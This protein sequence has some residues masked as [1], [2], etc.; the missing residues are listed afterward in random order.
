[1][2]D[3]AAG[4][5]PKTLL[6]PAPRLTRRP[7]TF[8]SRAPCSFAVYTREKN[9]AVYAETP[10]CA[11]VFGA[12]KTTRQAIQRRGPSARLYETPLTRPR[13]VKARVVNDPVS[14]MGCIAEPGGGCCGL[15]GLAL[16]L[17]RLRARLIRRLPLWV[18][19]RVLCE[20]ASSVALAWVASRFRMQPGDCLVV[21]Q[22]TSSPPPAPSAPL[23]PPLSPLHR[24][25]ARKGRMARE[26][27]HPR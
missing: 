26:R 6:R 20:S 21:R 14:P 23:A 1:M 4:G 22:A 11:A 10:D 9:E 25:S 3:A 18:V 12:C 7:H 8:Q 16:A 15:G 24:T 19:R 27:A 17:W 5:Y 13:H 2:G